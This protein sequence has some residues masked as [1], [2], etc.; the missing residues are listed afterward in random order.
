MACNLITTK[1]ASGATCSIAC[2]QLSG[3]NFYSD[4]PTLIFDGILYVDAGCTITVAAGYYSDRP[5][6]GTTCYTVNS[7]G[8]IKF[9][10]T[11]PSPTPT[12]TVTSTVTPTNTETPTNTP[13]N[14]QTPTV[15]PTEVYNVQF[16][17]CDDGSNIFR[18]FGNLYSLTLPYSFAKS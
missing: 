15:T 8:Q 11:C 10:G 16:R 7:S 6:G 17:D 14:T 9:I 3:T 18:F 2:A 12:P 5:D 4:N 13:T 1:L